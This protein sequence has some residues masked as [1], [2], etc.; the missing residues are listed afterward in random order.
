MFKTVK[1][2]LTASAVA[3]LVACGGGGGGNATPAA[4][5]GPVSSTLAFPVLQ[6]NRNLN[7]SGNT[8]VDPGV[9]TDLKVV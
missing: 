9:R 5:T 4:A 7:A 2:V 6:A 1:F 8:E 3:S